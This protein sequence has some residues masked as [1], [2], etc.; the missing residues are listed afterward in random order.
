MPIPTTPTGLVLA[1]VASCVAACLGTIWIFYDSGKRDDQATVTKTL[2]VMVSVLALAG[3]FVLV[4]A[5]GRSLGPAIVNML[6]QLGVVAGVVALITVAA[7]AM[8][9]SP[10]QVTCPSCFKPNDPSWTRCPYCGY[11]DQM[12][13]GE[14]EGNSAETRPAAQPETSPLQSSPSSDT[15]I[16]PPSGHFP[17]RIAWLT[18]LTGPQVGRDFRLASENRIGRD[19][20]REIVLTEANVSGR[21]AKLWLEGGA[22]VIQDMASRN[23]TWVNG[24]KIE[25]KWVLGDKDRLR[26][27]S[28]EFVFVDVG[29]GPWRGRDLGPVEDAG[30]S[31]RPQ[32]DMA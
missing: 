13:D 24:T 15:I 10:S 11:P 21:H 16:D 8:R 29:L 6:A 19:H 23:G 30:P 22:F 17:D 27:G 32:E 7:Y 28:T 18:A 9:R 2:S 1:T 31:G 14:A 5:F 4:P 20:D 3:A 26:I 25:K 12:A